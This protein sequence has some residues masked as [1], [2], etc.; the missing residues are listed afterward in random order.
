[1]ALSCLVPFSQSLPYVGHLLALGASEIPHYREHPQ[2]LEVMAEAD[3]PGSLG[4]W[5]QGMGAQA[6][7]SATAM[8]STMTTIRAWERLRQLAAEADEPGCHTVH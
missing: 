2:S 5:S 6:P 3:F 8:T 1:M 4:R 7:A